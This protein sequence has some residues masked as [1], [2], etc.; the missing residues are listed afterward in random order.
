M[1][2]SDGSQLTSLP[3]QYIELDDGIVLKRGCTEI[4]VRGQGMAEVARRI[5]MATTGKMTTCRDIC[6]SFPPHMQKLA[7]EVVEQLVARHML[8]S[9]SPEFRSNSL[10]ETHQDIFYWHFGRSADEIG[11]KLNRVSLAI[12][13][14]NYISK[15]LAKSLIDS[16]WSN[17][18]II[19]FPLLRDLRLF[20]EE[21]VLNEAMWSLPT[22]IHHNTWSSHWKDNPP[23]CLVVTSDFGGPTLIQR[24]NALAV[25]HKW[26]CFPIFLKNLVGSIGPFI[27]PGE[28]A[29][30]DC[31]CSREAS[32]FKDLQ[33]EQRVDEC[34]FFSQPFIGFAPAMTSILGELAAFELVKFYSGI[35]SGGNAGSLIEVNLMRPMIKV[36]R[37]LKLPRCAVCSPLHKTASIEIVN[38]FSAQTNESMT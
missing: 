13:G 36:R 18:Q 2:L 4:R 20:T 3:I 5:L 14:V 21:G 31:L 24:W 32:H 12:V 10:P 34:A 25:E 1:E 29:C 17:F 9:S 16:N 33:V 22:P 35:V 38:Q 30:F 15:Q 6:L 7:R 37:V 27:I 28:T 8:I 11:G 26:H 19:D 23:T